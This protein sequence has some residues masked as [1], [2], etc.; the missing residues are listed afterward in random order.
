MN[1]RIVR[2]ALAA[3]F[4]LGM[5][6]LVLA[7]DWP[8]FRG[9]H[10]GVA[11]PQDLP[12]KVTKESILWKVKMPGVGTSSPITYGDKIFVTAYKGY[13]TA[14]TKGMAGGFGGGKK[15]G[16]GFGGKGTPDADQKNLRLLVLC[17]DAN[18]GKIV[19][20]KEVA[21][22]FPEVNFSGMFRE[23]GY[24]SSTPATDGERVIAF[25]GKSGVHAFDMDGKP[26]WNVSVGSETHMWGSASSPVIHG[27]LVIVNAEIESKKLVALDKR[28]GKE[29][30][31]AK[32]LGTCWGSP[33]LVDTKEGKSELVMSW[34]GK[35]VAYDPLTGSQ[36]WSCEGIGTGGGGGGGGGGGAVAVASAARDSAAATRHRRRS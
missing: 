7:E 26:L 16:G 17:I 32:G 18:D 36:K 15:G 21:P 34:P 6:G 23:H 27:D 5:L 29:V 12:T 8:S 9:N 24:A 19:W 31:T 3:F 30:W 4:A 1:S 20:E 10:G 2:S 14:I 28:T 11:A 33:A 13:G 35:L 25:F 22:K